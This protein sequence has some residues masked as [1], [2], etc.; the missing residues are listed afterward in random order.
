VPSLRR[1]SRPLILVPVGALI[2]AALTPLALR[3]GQ[4]FFALS[5]G[6][7]LVVTCETSIGGYVTGAQARI[8]CA[9]P[10]SGG[11]DDPPP[12]DPTPAPEEG[13]TLT[14]ALV[15]LRDGQA[16][17]G[18]LAVEAL[19]SGGE[20][21]QV[22]FVLDGPQPAQH[23]ERRAPYF[24]LG[25]EG[26]QPRGWDTPKFPDGDYTLSVEVTATDGQVAETRVSFRVANGAAPSD[27]SEEAEPLPGLHR[28]AAIPGR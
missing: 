9:A 10:E 8:E 25:D 2:G 6:D 23:T 28:G 16:V 14:V 15:G 20:A 21:A 18:L 12:A 1:F 19:V 5:P 22:V 4:Q 13:N 17:D 7:S 3:A 11:E 26:G 27:T 24:F